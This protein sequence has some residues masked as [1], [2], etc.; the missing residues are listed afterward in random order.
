MMLLEAL[1]GRHPFTPEKQPSAMTLACDIMQHTSLPMPPGIS[2]EATDW[3]ARA[4]CKDPAGRATAEQLLE[5]PWLTMR[6]ASASPT[7]RPRRDGGCGRPER[8]PAPAAEEADVGVGSSAWG[9]GHDACQQ[10]SQR[11]P[12][13]SPQQQQ[14]QLRQQQP[15]ESL[16]SGQIGPVPTA[17]AGG[18]RPNARLA[19]G[20]ERSSSHHSP[21]RIGSGSGG[22][23]GGPV[24]GK[25]QPLL[26][27]WCSGGGVGVQGPSVVCATHSWE[28]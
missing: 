26:T 20:L 1:L 25:S 10:P 17:H 28:Y 11:P 27:T 22:G 8:M 19:C 16:Q 13:P 15:S 18:T 4:L 9:I 5:H 3:L 2:P 23:G 12:L 6:G 21:G 7:P 14:Q 24:P